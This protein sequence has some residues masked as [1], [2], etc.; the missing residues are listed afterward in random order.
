MT[1]LGALSVHELLRFGTGRIWF[2]MY[3]WTFV[4]KFRRGLA[5]GKSAR[6]RWN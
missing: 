4:S 2:I 6:R 3:S 5:E 1:R